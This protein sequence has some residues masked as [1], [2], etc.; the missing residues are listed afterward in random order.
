[1]NGNA[2]HNISTIVITHVSMKII[3]SF[4]F[5]A[6]QPNAYI[7]DAMKIAAGIMVHSSQ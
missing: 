7:I 3:D 5:N 6:I 2:P 1:M 4:G